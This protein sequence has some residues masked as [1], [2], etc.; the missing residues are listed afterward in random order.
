MPPKGDRHQTLVCQVSFMFFLKVMC[1]SQ[2][3][4]EAV[5]AGATW[6]G[7]G[8]G[9]S[10]GNGFN[11][12]LNFIAGVCTQVDGCGVDLGTLRE[13]HQVDGCGRS[14]EA[15]ISSWCSC[16]GARLTSMPPL[17]APA[18]SATKFARSTLRRTPSSKTAF[19]SASGG[20]GGLKRGG[21]HGQAGALLPCHC[22]QQPF[23]PCGL[24]MVKTAEPCL[25]CCTCSQQCGRFHELTAFDDHKRSCRERLQKHNARRRCRTD[26]TAAGM[27]CLACRRGLMHATEAPSLTHGSRQLRPTRMAPRSLQAQ[28]RRSG[29]RAGPRGCC[30]C[31]SR[32]H[33]P[34]KL[35]G[36]GLRSRR[37][38]RGAR[39]QRRQQRVSP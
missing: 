11:G 4:A 39:Q 16:H 5:P 36:Q 14:F 1:P 38:R 2:P 34:A 22:A 29:G 32:C 37:G 23:C 21:R 26:P 8:D 7:R 3:Q 20:I 30:C 15:L 18:R 12:V 25:P 13:Y 17:V 24:Q 9:A 35:W 31:R 19:S 10:P 28:G 33:R 6:A 27:T